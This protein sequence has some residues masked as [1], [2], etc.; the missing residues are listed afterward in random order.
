MNK[1]TSSLALF[2][3]MTCC[4]LCGS[5]S[6]K[7]DHRAAASVTFNR[8]VAPIFFKNCVD[9]HRP[10]EMAP[11]SLLTYKDARPWAR[12]IREK[13]ISRQMPP[14]SADPHYGDFSNDRRLSQSDI[15]TIVA[16]VDQ[17]ASQGNARDLRPAPSFEGKWA[18]GKPDIVLTMEKDY[19]LT[20]AG[21]DEYINIAIPTGFTENKWVQAMEVHP[22]NKKIVHHA[23]IFVQPPLLAENVKRIEPLFML[24]S[25][26]YSDGTLRRVKM[27]A[28]V[29]DNGCAAPFG[30]YA[31]G[32]GVETL[33][34]PLGF[35]APGKATDS[36]PEGTAKLVPAGSNLILQM[37]YSRATGKTE[38]DRTSVGLIFAKEPPEKPVFSFGALNF[39]FKLPA[40]DPNHE[41]KA[42][43]TFG[44][45]VR[46]LDFM[47]HM[48]LRG[49]DMK[50]EAF[51]PNGSHEILI[52]VPSYNFNWQ[53]LYKL[54][55]PLSIPKG[56]RLVV[57]AHYDNSE[58][59]KYNPD[60]AKSV[61]FGDPTYDEMMIG[62]FDYISA[63]PGRSEALALKLD[64]KLL[65]S[66]AGTYQI[67][68]G[69][70]FDVVRKG[71]GLNV[72]VL[73]TT[74]D[75]VPE[76]D[77]QFSVDAIDAVV[78]FVKDGS[79]AVRGMRIELAGMPVGARKQTP[80]KPTR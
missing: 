16:W 25:I 14:W 41:V 46:M 26:F 17:G 77:V 37:H 6:A 54:K 21:S 67:L 35:Y 57:T 7:A 64:E 27:D 44:R 4:L 68:P 51:Y 11:M 38:T 55:R 80:L 63:G 61:R 19:V 18:I 52:D 72:T 28:P 69:I 79:G 24:N 45:D 5:Y 3:L 1:R 49:K 48:H 30:G 73:G 36:W 29:Y 56:T 9:C 13:V 42:C 22:G 39:Y 10:G 53:T 76:S 12:S 74:V 59:N 2:G 58:K 62:Y 15:D 33:G 75:L 50:Y 66:Y 31:F 47:P 20:S 70:E 65:D 40:G 32:S 78:T 71:R 60:P 43:Y 34:M 23:V 8:D